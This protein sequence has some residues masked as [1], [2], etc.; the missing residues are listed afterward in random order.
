[1]S[2]RGMW[3]DKSLHQLMCMWSYSCLSPALS[4][5]SWWVL[6]SIPSRSLQL[7]RL[8]H[9]QTP[10]S[11]PHP[12]SENTPPQTIRTMNYIIVNKEII[13]ITGSYSLMKQSVTT[14]PR[15]LKMKCLK[16]SSTH[17]RS[18]PSLGSLFLHSLVLHG[19]GDTG[20]DSPALWGGHSLVLHLNHLWFAYLPLH[21]SSRVLRLHLLLL[22]ILHTKQINTTL[23]SDRQTTCA[24]IG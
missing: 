24:P 21:L 2:W 13:S 19:T 11:S 23:V 14:D 10:S 17:L 22:Q 5:F 1:M 4:W 15:L 9:H 8:R 6:R 7:L 12:P 16:S 3:C 18:F 20:D